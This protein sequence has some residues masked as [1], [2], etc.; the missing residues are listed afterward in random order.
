MTTVA[1]GRIRSISAALALGSSSAAPL[2]AT[3][4]GSTTTGASRTSSSAAATASIVVSSPSIPTLTAST[5]MSSTTALTWATM[6][7]GGIGAIAS[8]PVVF[9]AVIAVIAQVP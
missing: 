5:P 3:I 7:S 2:E 9:W 4:T 8:T 1:S 6:I